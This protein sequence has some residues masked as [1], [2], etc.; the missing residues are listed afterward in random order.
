[1]PTH[2]HVANAPASLQISQRAYGAQMVL[3]ANPIPATKGSVASANVCSAQHI[4]GLTM[5][6]YIAS[7]PKVEEMRTKFEHDGQLAANIAPPTPPATPASTST[8]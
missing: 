1:M 3:K 4:P 5:P 6:P 2:A 7:N 8:A